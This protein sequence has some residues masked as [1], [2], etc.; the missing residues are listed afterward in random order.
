MTVSVGTDFGRRSDRT[1]SVK[2]EGDPLRMRLVQMDLCEQARWNDLVI[3]ARNVGKG[4]DIHLADATGVGD[5]LYEHI[6]GAIG[7]VHTGK[8]H[9]PFRDL[10]GNRISVVKSTLY[11][12]VVSAIHSR[13]L[14]VDCEVPPHFRQELLKFSSKITRTGHIKLEASSGHDDTISALALALFGL[15]LREIRY[16]HS[17]EEEQHPSA[18]AAVSSGGPV[19]NEPRGEPQPRSVR[20]GRR[21]PLG[22]IGAR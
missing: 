9:E 21:S 19:H 8:Q 2:V 10:P 7:I 17:Y 11:L 12:P 18:P 5:A 4:A 1:C 14:T 13:G 16:G 6:P 20:F 15:Y 3:R 22:R